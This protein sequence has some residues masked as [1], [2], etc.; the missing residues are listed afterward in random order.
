MKTG[1]RWLFCCLYCTW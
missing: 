1:R